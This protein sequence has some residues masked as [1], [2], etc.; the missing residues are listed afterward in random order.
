MAD[1]EPEETSMQSSEGA[2]E[3]TN[4]SVSTN[5]FVFYA[6]TIGQLNP[7][8][9]SLAPEESCCL[10]V[11]VCDSS[12]QV[13]ASLLLGTDQESRRSFLADCEPKT[14]V[15]LLEHCSQEDREVCWSSAKNES[16]RA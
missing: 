14:I 13:L 1:E 6:S 12:N 11:L 2:N 3:T 8:N 7:T 5:L 9:A 10:D 4:M 16:E 15:A